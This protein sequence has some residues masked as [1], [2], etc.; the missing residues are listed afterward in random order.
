[1][2]VDFAIKP[3]HAV[4]WKAPAMAGMPLFAH[5][6]REEKK[7]PPL[8]ECLPAP[9]ELIGFI[10]KLTTPPVAGW[11]LA[12]VGVYLHKNNEDLASSR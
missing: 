5:A 11:V 9:L 4:L 3:A 1:M 2:V 8:P 6:G 10:E 12:S 7:P